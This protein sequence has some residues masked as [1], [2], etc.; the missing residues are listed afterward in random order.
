MHK[1]PFFNDDG[2]YEMKDGMS[3]GFTI[4]ELIKI[5][6]YDT[7]GDFFDCLNSFAAAKGESEQGSN[8]DRSDI[9]LRAKA[10][11]TIDKIN[12]WSER[13]VYMTTDELLEK[14]PRCIGNH[15]GNGCFFIFEEDD[16]IG[17]LTLINEGGNPPCCLWW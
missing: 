3:F 6:L 13:S 1:M 15:G 16:Q 17:W 14:L 9:E 7:E 11:E 5:R 10:A 4:D 12:S 2:T 8:T